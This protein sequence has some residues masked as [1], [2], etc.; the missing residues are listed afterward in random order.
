[1]KF[2]A[3]ILKT[4]SGNFHYE[5]LLTVNNGFIGREKTKYRELFGIHVRNLF[6]TCLFSCSLDACIAYSNKPKDIGGT[7]NTYLISESIGRYT[8]SGGHSGIE[9]SNSR[10]GVYHCTAACKKRNCSNSTK[11]DLLH[12]GLGIG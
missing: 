12:C 2:P 3:A 4:T 8:L 7:R 6:N 9:R 1:M 10:G 5:I 11:K